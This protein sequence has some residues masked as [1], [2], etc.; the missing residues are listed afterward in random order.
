M[1]RLVLSHRLYQYGPLQ[2]PPLNKDLTQSSSPST[3]ASS[4][5]P[6]DSC[7]ILSPPP[8][9][10]SAYGALQAVHHPTPVVIGKE[11]LPPEQTIS[12]QP[13][14][15]ADGNASSV[16][17]GPSL[18]SQSDPPP[19][20]AP[21]TPQS[22]SSSPASPM[23]TP[24]KEN[25]NLFDGGASELELIGITLAGLAIISFVAFVFA[26][27]RKNKNKH[28]EIFVGRHPPRNFSE[29]LGN[30]LSLSYD[31]CNSIL[32]FSLG[33]NQTRSFS[34]PGEGVWCP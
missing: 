6:L 17:P 8:V 29:K 25:P 34:P 33:W 1:S 32:F 23:A 13:E 16:Y 20:M 7:L 12:L 26:L 9:S 4:P 10:L 27:I 3:S 5:P 22:N 2:P 18:T 28:A 30:D 24:G 31:F 15:P 11:R 14:T 21:P 19:Q